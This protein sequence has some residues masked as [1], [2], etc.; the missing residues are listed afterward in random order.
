[1]TEFKRGAGVV[2]TCGPLGL[3]K[4]ENGSRFVGGATVNEG[5][6]GIYWGP[7]S[8]GTIQEGWHLVA[9][10]VGEEVYFA[11]VHMNQFTHL[12][13]VVPQPCNECPWR[14]VALSGYLGPHSPKEWIRMA[15]GESAIA[16]HKTIKVSESWEGTRQCAGA[17]SFRA[18]VAKTP[19]DPSVAYGPA[20]EDVFPDN[21]A[22]L[23]HHAPGQVWEM[24]DM[25]NREDS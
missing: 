2:F 23:D 17:A 11:P 9:V 22:F 12:P 14:K 4:E 16:C 21:Q 19:R 18:N 10:E 5:D 6:L 8:W 15:H 20:R 7:I 25:Y 1:M 24:A 3:L 13:D